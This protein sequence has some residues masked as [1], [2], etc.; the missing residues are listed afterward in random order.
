MKGF[1]MVSEHE[2]GWLRA[3]LAAVEALLKDAR[4]AGDPVGIM[5]CEH[6]RQERIAQIA[7][8]EKCPFDLP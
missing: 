7:E 5:Q 8:I 4:E 1:Q 6:R 2:L 3:D